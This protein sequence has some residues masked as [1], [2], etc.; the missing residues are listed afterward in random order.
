MGKDKYYRRRTIFDGCS[1]RS[2]RVFFP[3]GNEFYIRNLVLAT[4][5]IISKDDSDFVVV[6]VES[7]TVRLCVC[8][9][10]NKRKNE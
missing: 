9:S 6:V 2:G 7:L 4:G 8:Y 3:V 1:Y 5:F 10:A